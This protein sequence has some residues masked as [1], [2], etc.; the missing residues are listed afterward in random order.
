[1]A[2]TKS[3]TNKAKY[4][5]EFQKLTKEKNGIEKANERIQA[6]INKNNAA[7]KK[8]GDEKFAK[9]KEE[10]AKLEKSITDANKEYKTLEKNFFK[11]EDAAFKVEAAVANPAAPTDAEKKAIADAWALFDAENLKYMAKKTEIDNF[12]A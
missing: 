8:A 10:V 3:A 12:T 7:E 1:L 11:L 4:E 9:D 6:V 5:E 2:A